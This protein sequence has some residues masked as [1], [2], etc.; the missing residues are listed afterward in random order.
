[1][2]E[3]KREIKD[4]T[5]IRKRWMAKLRDEKRAHKL[6]ERVGLAHRAA[7]P[8]K[9]LSGGEKQRVA[10][11][12]AFCNDPQIIMADEPSGNLDHATSQMI[13]DLL[14]GCVSEEGKAL[15][16][17]THDQELAKLCDRTL[18]LINGELKP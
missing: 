14:L 10:I 6:L 8:A 9:L 13:H 12:R 7:F 1:M 11:A 17:V 16:V 15:V 3:E 5:E 2:S 4:T 18:F